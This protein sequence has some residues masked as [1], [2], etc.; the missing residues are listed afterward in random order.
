[1]PV[2]HA[3]NE[4]MISL[5]R[6]G[7][8]ATFE[9]LPSLIAKKAEGAELSQAR[10][11]LADHQQQVL[12]EFTGVGLDAHEGGEALSVNDSLAGQAYVT[13]VTVRV[14]GEHR[15]W[16]PVL[17]GAQRLGVMH[18]GYAG[19]PDRSAM[20]DLASM[21]ALL[22]IAKRSN[23]DSYARLVRTKP[24]SV[25]AEMQWTLMPPGTF[26][27][28]RVTISAATEP[29]YD[30]AGDAFDYAVAG[31]VAHLAM[32]DAMGHDTAAGLIA[33]LAVGAF[34]NERRKGTELAQM[35]R[36]VEET[37][38]QEFVRTRFATAVLAELNMTT[39]ELHWVNCGHLPPVLIRNNQVRSLECE[40][41]HPLGM[42]LGLPVTVCREQLEPG[43]RLLLYTDG[44]IE[45]RDSQGREFGVERFVDF[46]IRHQADNMPV[47][48]TLRRL[49]HGVLEYHHGRFGDDATVLFCEWHG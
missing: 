14:E 19:D 12:R 11:Y 35:C 29:A 23:S 27:D 31:E 10:V 20:R 6:A 17:E 34:R 40:P 45:A 39:G 37:L 3:S 36:G 18:V 15:Y 46:V 30:N 7:H 13:G 5:V 48:E 43:D 22:V 38:I 1:M 47:P 21:V 28:S 2:Q 42:D 41:S 49:V 16:V 26:A 9:E 24:M 32:F 44:I 8:L 4:L 25:S 33:N